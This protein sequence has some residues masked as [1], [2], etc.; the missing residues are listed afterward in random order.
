M[1]SHYCSNK[2]GKWRDDVTSPRKW[3]VSWLWISIFCRWLN[4]SSILL[5]RMMMILKPTYWL[6]GICR[7]VHPSAQ[8]WSSYDIVSKGSSLLSITSKPKVAMT[9]EYEGGLVLGSQPLALSSPAFKGSLMRSSLC[10]Q[11]SMMA[12][13]EMYGDL[14]LL[15]KDRYWDASEPRAPYTAATVS[16]LHQPSFQGSTFDITWVLEG[17]IRTNLKSCL[18]RA[19]Q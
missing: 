19:D 16:M 17:T 14:P 8:R 13:D 6:I 12:V 4:N 1:L 3:V 10:S 9:Q 15:E 18:S 2:Q 11:V 7:S 5:G